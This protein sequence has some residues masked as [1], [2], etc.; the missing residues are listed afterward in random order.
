MSLLNHS[1]DP[2]CSIVFNGPHLLLRAVREIEAGEEVRK[3]V[4]PTARPLFS[5]E[6][7]GLAPLYGQLQLTPHY[8]NTTKTFQTVIHQTVDESM[9]TFWSW[10]LGFFMMIV[11]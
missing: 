8:P 3:P 9:H 5:A 6:P 11:L 1:C 2:N 10:S 4:P 7:F